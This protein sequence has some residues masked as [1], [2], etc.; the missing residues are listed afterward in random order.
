MK[1]TA[2]W[3]IF[4]S[5]FVLASV[6][7]GVRVLCRDF[8][9]RWGLAVHWLHSQAREDTVTQTPARRTTGGARAAPL[10]TN[11]RQ[12][13]LPATKLICRKRS[14]SRGAPRAPARAAPAP[15]PLERDDERNQAPGTSQNK[16]KPPPFHNRGSSR[17]SRKPIKSNEIESNQ[18]NW[19]RLLVVVVCAAIGCYRSAALICI[20][21]WLQL[22]PALKQKTH[23]NT[24]HSAI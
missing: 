22:K 13:T 20:P 19:N 2:A 21:G 17:N 9:H 7:V 5:V 1:Q 16:V 10:F 15:L 18:I 8:G 4:E 11:P 3:Q 24:A 14:A 12:S 6:L 23:G